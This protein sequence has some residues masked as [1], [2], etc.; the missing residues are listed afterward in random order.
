MFHYEN[1]SHHLHCVNHDLNMFI[2]IMIKPTCTPHASFNVI[3]WRLQSERKQVELP[4]YGF[5]NK[6][7]SM[8]LASV[9]AAL[10]SISS[11]TVTNVSGNMNYRQICA[12][13][14]FHFS[15]F[16]FMLVFWSFVN[17]SDFGLTLHR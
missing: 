12:L 4:C 2:L 6:Y 14:Y 1:C 15:I 11:E 5:L 8:F 9:N 10:V 3:E 16:N 17:M 7:N 13:F